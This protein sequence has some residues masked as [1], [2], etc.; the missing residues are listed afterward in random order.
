MKK[1]LLLTLLSVVSALTQVEAGAPSLTHPQSVDAAEPYVQV[2]SAVL[3]PSTIHKAGQPRTSTVIVQIMLRGEVPPNVTAR[4][5]VGTYSTDPPGNDV[6]YE[7]QSQAAPLKE[8]LTVVKFNLT[9]SSQ[10]VPGKIVVA[11]IIHSTTKGVNIKAPEEP[12]D[13]HAELTILDH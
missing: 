13:W 4:V 11:A 6:A 9:S 3:D 7:Q 12:K 5:D 10:T 1:R 8:K 2:T